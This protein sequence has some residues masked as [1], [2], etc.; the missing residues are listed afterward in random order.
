MGADESTP[1]RTRKQKETTNEKKYAQAHQ[2]LFNPL[3]HDTT[4]NI[5]II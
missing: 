3:A 1:Q 5:F 4:G 2:T